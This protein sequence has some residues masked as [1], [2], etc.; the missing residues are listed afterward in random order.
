[1][2]NAR[3]GQEPQSAGAPEGTTPAGLFALLW[4]TLADVLGTAA[5]A[6]LLR[7]AARR[8]SAHGPVLNGVVIAREGLTYGYRLPEA[9][10]REDSAKALSALDALVQELRPL[11]V[12]LT[13]PVLVRRLDRLAPFRVRGIR[14]TLQEGPP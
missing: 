11:L 8:A 3:Q 12:E 2:T 6:T 5:A 1:M 13:G 9:W 14:F 7:R 4:D 10:E